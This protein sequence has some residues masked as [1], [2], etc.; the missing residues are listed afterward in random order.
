MNNHINM[1]DVGEEFSYAGLLLALDLCERV[2]A[3]G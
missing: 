2:G 3:W 1:V